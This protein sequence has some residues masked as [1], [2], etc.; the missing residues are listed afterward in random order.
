MFWSCS[1]DNP[2]Q[3]LKR[4]KHQCGS[5]ILRG[6]RFFIRYYGPDRTQKNEFSVRRDDW[7]SRDTSRS[8]RFRTLGLGAE[9]EP[10]P[11]Q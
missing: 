10:G 2:K 7:Y 3:H 9:V 1:L 11:V 4:R 8:S 6:H 5:V